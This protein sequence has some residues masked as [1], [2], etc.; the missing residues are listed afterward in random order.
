MFGETNPHRGIMI[1]AAIGLGQRM[2]A[3]EEQHDIEIARFQ[4]VIDQLSEQLLSTQMELASERCEIAGLR[5]YIQE[6]R[7]QDPNT[8]ALAPSGK[9]F[10]SGKP[11]S[12]AT[13]VYERAYDNHADGLGLPGLKGG[14]AP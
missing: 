6:V 13:L 10:K 11:K 2:R 4:A 5:A 8:P 1:G 9:H 7:R 12:L 14:Y 3:E